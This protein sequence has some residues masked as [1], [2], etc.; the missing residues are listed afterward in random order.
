MPG[1]MIKKLLAFWRERDGSAPIE[2]SLM[3]LVILPTIFGGIYLWFLYSLQSNLSASVYRAAR[4]VSTEGEYMRVWPNDPLFASRTVILRDIRSQVG[5]NVWLQPEASDNYE[6]SNPDTLRVRLY[7]ANGLPLSSKPKCTGDK[8]PTD[9]PN[10]RDRYDFAIDAQLAL[11]PIRLPIV[12]NFIGDRR[13]TI[14]ARHVSYL[15]CGQSPLY[16]D[17]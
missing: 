8:Q 13:L 17:P 14:S 1:A 9:D 5:R 4:Y 11:P 12:S 2:F 15:E 10:V 6:I 3:L 7:D 16:Y